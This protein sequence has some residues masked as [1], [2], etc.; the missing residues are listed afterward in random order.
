[1]SESDVDT[2]VVDNGMAPTST[3]WEFDFECMETFPPMPPWSTPPFWRHVT[4][5]NS[6]SS[7]TFMELTDNCGPHVRGVCDCALL[8]FQYCCQK[9]CRD[10]V[11]ISEVL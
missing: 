4:D 3:N 2:A 6:W 10:Q 11:Q 8:G 5:G 1:M 9:F 7:T